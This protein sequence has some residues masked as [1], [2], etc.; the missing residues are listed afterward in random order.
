MMLSIARSKN[1]LEAV[2]E[3]RERVA[4]CGSGG[5]A[6][7]HEPDHRQLDHGL[8]DLGQLLV[9]P[10][11]AAPAAEPAERPLRHPTTREEDEALG[12][13]EAPDDDQRQ[14]E[15]EAGEQGREPVVDP[16]GEHRPQPRVEPLQALEEIADA[17]RVLDVGGVDD[18]AEQQA[19]GV[20]PDVPLPAPHLLRRVVAAGPPFSVVLTL[21]VS[22]MTALGLGS[23]PS[24][25]RSSITRWWRMLSHTPASANA[26]M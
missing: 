16:V 18:H 20:D 2:C 21:W 6:V 14:P 24:R 1:A 5:R 11:E 3:V 8:G 23:R 22:T 17:V 25:S 12:P 9:V 10:G 7:Q 19:R 15:Q 4:A 26:R 13:G